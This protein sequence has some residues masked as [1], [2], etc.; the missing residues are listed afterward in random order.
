MLSLLAIVIAT[1]GA[2]AP[3]RPGEDAVALAEAALAD[4][5]PADAVRFLKSAAGPHPYARH[6]RLYEQL[7][8]AYAYLDE[9]DQA[10]RAFVRM[11]ALDPA[12]AISY[13]LSPKVTFLFERARRE[14]S[15]RA[16]PAIDLSWPRNLRTVDPVPVEIEVLADPLGFLREAR[17]RY[18]LRGDPSWSE[19]TVELADGPGGFVVVEVPALAAGA[20]SSRTLELYAVALDSEANEVLLVGRP[21]RPREVDLRYERPEPWFEK[22]WVWAAAGAAVAAGTTAAVV[23]A[24]TEPGPTVGGSFRWE[25]P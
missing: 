8:I 16:A 7:G 11:L 14:A 23:A 6:V 13:T 3:A 10:V 2:A 24:S 17:L 19:Q 15:A 18:R 12:R 5:R 25:V 21:D 1:S 22:W 4:F 9:P 20:A